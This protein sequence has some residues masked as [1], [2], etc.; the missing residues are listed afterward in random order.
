MTEIAAKEANRVRRAAQRTEAAAEETTAKAGGA[1]SVHAGEAK[2]KV[3]LF[4][5]MAAALWMTL[6]PTV[7]GQ[8]PS[9][10]LHV[11]DF[12]QGRSGWMGSHG[13]R[14]WQPWGSL[15]IPAKLPVPKSAE[16]SKRLKAAWISEIKILAQLEA[17]QEKFN[18][19][20]PYRAVIP[21]TD[22]HIRWIEELFKAYGLSLDEELYLVGP[23]QSLTEAYEKSKI[24][25]N[26]LLP[27]FEWLVKNAEDRESARVLDAI[28]IRSRIHYVLFEHVIRMG[29]QAYG[30]SIRGIMGLDYGYIFGTGPGVTVFGNAENF[31][32]GKPITA[33][34]AKSLVMNYLKSSKNPNLR[35]GRVKDVGKSFEVEILTV[36][37][38]LVDKILVDKSRGRMR[39]AYLGTSKE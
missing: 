25:E 16:W 18:A 23:A 36:T 6:P 4:V 12:S 8:V 19:F 35:V 34:G 17:D 21:Q 15:H 10:A 33:S 29:V 13:L 11:A 39:S 1:R 7:N 27:Q 14:L 5:L 2:K 3:F 22:Q 26:D 38:S 28:L 31:S 32:D 9:G 24:K 20:M 37:N 30:F